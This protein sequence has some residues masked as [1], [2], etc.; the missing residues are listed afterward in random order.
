MTPVLGAL[1]V[2]L[3]ATC[4][5]CALWV[6]GDYAWR[7]LRWYKAKQDAMRRLD[8][9]TEKILA[10]GLARLSFTGE[11]DDAHKSGFKIEGGNNVK[12]ENCTA[13]YLGPNL[14]VYRAEMPNTL[15]PL[16]L[17][18][19]V[20]YDTEGENLEMVDGMLVKKVVC[21]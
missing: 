8:A 10:T 6:L 21:P 15:L 14:R 7:Y 16:P 18:D 4:L 17:M 19:G 3:A 11:L 13:H 20:Y 9:E 2:T 12:F 1:A 5:V